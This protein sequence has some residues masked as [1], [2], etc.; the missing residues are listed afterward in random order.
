MRTSPAISSPTRRQFLGAFGV[1]TVGAFVGLPKFTGQAD[2]ATTAL[3]DLIVTALSIPGS[4]TSGQSIH[5]G[6]TIKNQ[7]TIQT[8]GGIEIGA[9]FF[10]DGVEIAWSGTD[11]QALAAGAT[12]SL[13][14]DRGGVAGTGAWIATAGTHTLKVFV[15]DTQRFSEVSRTNNT[16]TATFTVGGST[17][18]SAK[19]VNS[20]LPVITGTATVGQM[21]STS[22]GTWT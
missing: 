17:T 8:P 11:F 7:G 16:L 15:N 13:K 12:T 21:L 18:A 9:G 1:L 4:I 2:A 14:T 20:A 6:A 10:V 3:P 19:P 22:T 5:F